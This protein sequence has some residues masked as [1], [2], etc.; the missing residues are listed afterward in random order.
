M[1]VCS[2]CVFLFC[3]V[4]TFYCLFQL[5]C[6][7]TGQAY[8]PTL[9]WVNIPLKLGIFS[10]WFIYLFIFFLCC[11]LHHHRIIVFLHQRCRGLRTL[12]GFKGGVSH[13]NHLGTG[14][15]FLT[16]LKPS[17]H[18]RSRKGRVGQQILWG[19]NSDTQICAICCL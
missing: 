10:I 3:L 7:V 13:L 9:L 1:N 11:A 15:A 14:I 8:F 2:I 19:H 18:L 17:D 4:L 16:H 12:L 6:M 5:S